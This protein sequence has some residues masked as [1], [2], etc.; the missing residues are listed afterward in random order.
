[1][2]KLVYIEWED[3]QGCSPSW[4]RTA[5]YD[6]EVVIIKSVGWIIHENKKT[7]SIAGNIAEETNTTDAQANGIMT[8]PKRC[9][10]KR[11]NV[12]L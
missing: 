4:Q 2:K 3:S 10:V 1:M 9:V 8:I 12:S 11:K 6:P 5:N 7:I